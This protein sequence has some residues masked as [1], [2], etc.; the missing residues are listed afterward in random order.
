[1]KRQNNEPETY[2]IVKTIFYPTFNFPNLT[3]KI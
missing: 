3:D 1:M 2:N